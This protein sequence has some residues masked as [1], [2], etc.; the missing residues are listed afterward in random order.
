MPALFC[1]VDD[2]AGIRAYEHFFTV[3]LMLGQVLH[4]YVTKTAQA[5]VHRNKGEINALDFKTFHQFP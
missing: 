1:R 4:V 2:A 3:H 5:A